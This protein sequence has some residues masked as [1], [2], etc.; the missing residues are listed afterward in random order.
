MADVTL[1]LTYKEREALNFV[2]AGTEAE[3]PFEESIK[4]IKQ[5]VSRLECQPGGCPYC[6]SDAGREELFRLTEYDD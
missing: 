6:N 2:L 5:K 4:A 1:E 3:W